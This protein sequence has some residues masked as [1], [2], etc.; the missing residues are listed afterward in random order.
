MSKDTSSL[1]QSL[2]DFEPPHEMVAFVEKCGRL[3]DPG[4]T[5]SSDD[6]GNLLMMNRF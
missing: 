3:F 4:L 5:T 1:A 2:G 6:S